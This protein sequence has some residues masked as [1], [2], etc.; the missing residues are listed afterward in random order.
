MSILQNLNLVFRNLRRKNS[1]Y[2]DIIV[3]LIISVLLGSGLAGAVSLAADTYF[4]KTV[5]SLVGD[6]GE[7][8]IVIQTREEMREDAAIQIQKIIGEA[9]P[10]A[11]FK[12]GP[13]ITGK[14]SFFVALPDQYKTKKIYEELGKTFGSIPG[15]GGVGVMTEPRLTVRGV[16]EGAKSMLMDQIAAMEGVR[17]AFRD[18][19]SIGVVLTSINKASIISDNIE[20]MLK[21]YQV[22][23]ISFP[24]GSEPANPIRM[25]DTIADSLQKELKLQVAKNVSVDGRNDDMTYMVST[26][27]EIKRFLSAYASQVS[28]KVAPGIQLVKGDSVLF[29]DNVL[30]E[31]TA[32]RSNGTAEGIITR[33]DAADITDFTGYKMV[34]GEIGPVAGTAVVQNPRAQFSDALKEAVKLTAQIPGF[35]SDAREMSSVAVSALDNYGES[36]K[37]IDGTLS[38][39]QTAGDAIQTATSGLANLDTSALQA[40]LNNSS[41]AMGGLIST[42]QV[43]KLINQDVGSSISS[44]S[45][46]QQNLNSLSAGLQALD[47]VSADARRAQSTINNIVA[48]GKTTMAKLQTFDVNGARS[49]LLSIQGRLA[50]VEEMNIPLIT[51]QLNYLAVSVPNLKDE[52]INRSTGIL[53][54]FISGQVIPGARIQILTTS[55][56]VPEAAMPVVSKQVGHANASVYSAALGVIEPNPRTELFGILNEV[57]AIMAGMTAMIVTVLLLVLDHTAIMTV[58]RRKRM[59]KIPPTKGLR[60]RLAAIVTSVTASEKQYGMA[61]GAIMLSAMFVLSKA[62]IP[63]LNFIGVPLIGALLGLI[64]AHYAERISPVAQEEIMAGEALGLSV[65]DIMREIVIPGA[66]PGLLQKVNSRKVKF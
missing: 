20:K 65:D 46:A 35:A 63:Y 37:A 13:T 36:I 16:P 51:T 1:F 8:D 58:I 18:G 49:N 7:Y 45:N 34:K 5:A 44:L 59:Q 54:K 62:S 29:K 22:L 27:M 64:I 9:F 39:L 31:I 30:V 38:G 4:S 40:Q 52:E 6:Y 56:L 60:K 14:T 55:N 10:G 32:V 2:R 43:A 57:R 25:G 21:Q 47:R 19:S 61:I 15:G 24:V 42:L 17:F 48:N 33:G 41:Q 3:L 53:D 12:E 28:I 66:R 50:K 23:E 26:M 11:K